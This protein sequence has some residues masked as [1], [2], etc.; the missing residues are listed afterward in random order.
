LFQKS[1]TYK[2]PDQLAISGTQNPKNL[3]KKIKIQIR[4]YKNTTKNPTSLF[5]TKLKQT[6]KIKE[7]KEN[8]KPIKNAKIPHRKGCQNNQ[9]SVQTE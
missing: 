1:N 9:Q 3:N 4:T 2:T 6:K 5:P 7:I 8:S